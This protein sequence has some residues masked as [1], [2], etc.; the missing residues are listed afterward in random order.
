MWK[1]EIV[2]EVRRYREEYASQFDF[3]L[4]AIFQDLKE[5]EKQHPHRIVS[6]CRDELSKSSQPPANV[7]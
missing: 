2:E 5:K 3:D 4:E 7:V 1:D 6:F